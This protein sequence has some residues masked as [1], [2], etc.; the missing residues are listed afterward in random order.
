MKTLHWINHENARP[1]IQAD[2]VSAGPYVISCR[3]GRFVLSYRPEGYHTH[4]GEFPDLDS[5][6]QATARHVPTRAR[7]C[8]DDNPKLKD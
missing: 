5:A 7:R 1:D 4:L 8:L 2:I 6:K 3:P